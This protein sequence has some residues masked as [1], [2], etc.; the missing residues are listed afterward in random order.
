M[1]IKFDSEGQENNWPIR[2]KENA[3][4]RCIAQSFKSRSRVELWDI[5]RD[6]DTSTCFPIL[7]GYC[8]D[9]LHFIQC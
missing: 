5:D 7:I 2:K 8:E 4:L 9:G 3:I 1:Y 6:W